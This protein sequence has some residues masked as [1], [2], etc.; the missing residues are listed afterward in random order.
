MKPLIKYPGGKTQL[1]VELKKIITPELLE[2]QVY[3]EPFCGGASLALDL[4][5]KKCILNDKNYELMNL[6]QTVVR[7]PED[8]IR[9]L[10]QYQAAHS[11][12]FYYKVREQDRLDIWAQLDMVHKAA[13]YMY[14]NRT[15]F[16]GLMRYNKRGYFNSPIGRTS[17]GKLPDIVQADVIREVSEYLSDHCDL[18]CGDY[19]LVTQYAKPG[20][21]VFL[22][23]PYLET[24]SDY[25]AEGFGL[26]ETQELKLE[27]DRLDSL[28]VNWVLTNDNN[29]TIKELFKGYEIREVSVRRNI[30]RKGTGR[31]GSEVIITNIR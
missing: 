20:D 14:L 11:T 15:C 22:D 2:G 23:P 19:R 16:N 9:V 3:F 28:G 8:L 27:C 6:Y 10:T 18:Y 17:S 24:W 31:T 25:T 30:N 13:R 5:P 26:A 29:D 12:D 4:Q 7:K 21:V 1:L